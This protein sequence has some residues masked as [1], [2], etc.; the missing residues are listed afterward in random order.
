MV[1]LIHF[2]YKK[3]KSPVHKMTMPR[4]N[5]LE[6]VFWVRA[7]VSILCK[8][9]PPKMYKIEFATKSDELC[10]NGCLQNI[11]FFK[12]F[13]YRKNKSQDQ[14]MTMPRVNLLE[15]FFGLVLCYSFCAK[16]TLKC[17]TKTNF[18]RNQ[19]NGVLTVG[20]R[21]WCFCIH[22]TYSKNK[23]QDQKMTMPRGNFLEI[24]FWLGLCYSFSAKNTLQSCTKTNLQRNQ[25]NCVLKVGSKLW[26]FFYTFY[27]QKEQIAGTK[28]DHATRKYPGNIFWIRAFVFLLCKE[29]PL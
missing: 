19:T 7:L 10:L 1:F 17:C 21:I 2:T 3:N 26:C 11:V 27:V 29:D 28:N 14:K 5:L 6:I 18:Q 15:I 16:N 23:S 13:I 12:H 20:S 25:T 24:F 8:E 9:H 4:G 22:F